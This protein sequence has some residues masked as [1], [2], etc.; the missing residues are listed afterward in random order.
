VRAPDSA[1]FLGAQPEVKEVA[2]LPFKGN[3]QYS[4][5]LL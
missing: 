3:Y 1:F 4:Y 5:R 2:P